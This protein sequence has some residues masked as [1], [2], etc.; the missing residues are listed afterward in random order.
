MADEEDA[1]EPRG[2]RE[3]GHGLPDLRYSSARGKRGQVPE[4]LLPLGEALP[5]RGSR[6]WE[7]HHVLQVH[8][9]ELEH[10]AVNGHPEKLRV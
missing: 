4:Q 7:V 9:L 6:E 5:V 8:S 10:D 3:E 2:E 1:R